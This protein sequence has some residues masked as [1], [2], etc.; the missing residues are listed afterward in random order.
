MARL[1]PRWHRPNR[2]GDSARSHAALRHACRPPPPAASSS[3][4]SGSR[5]GDDNASAAVAAVVAAT[6]R[7]TYLTKVRARDGLTLDVIRS[8][9]AGVIQRIKDVFLRCD[10]ESLNMAQFVEL[11]SSGIADRL[12]GATTRRDLVASLVDLF[13][14]M[15][16]DSNMDLEFEEFLATV[17]QLGMASAAAGPGLE[18]VPTYAAGRR[19]SLG[20]H[21]RDPDRVVKFSPV[22]D[23]LVVYEPAQGA[24]SLYHPAD[25]TKRRVLGLNRRDLLCVEFMERGPAG[26]PLNL[27]AAANADAVMIWD[28]SWATGAPTPVAHRYPTR[29]PQTSL[30]WSP[31]HDRLFTGSNSGAVHVVHHRRTA[32]ACLA[33]R[34]HSHGHDEMVACMDVLDSIDTLATGSLDATVRLW[35]IHTGHSTR[36][37]KAHRKGVA[38]LAYSAEYKFLISAGLDRDACVWSPFASH[39]MCKLTGHVAPLVDVQFVSGTPQIV[40]AD[41]DGVVK[42]WDA[43]NFQCCQTLTALPSASSFACCTGPHRRLVF[44]SDDDA[45]A[46]VDVENGPYWSS[47]SGTAGATRTVSCVLY[48]PYALSFAVAVGNRLQIWDGLKGHLVSVAELACPEI[49]AMCLGY[50]GKKIIVG[51]GNGAIG[52]YNYRNGTFLKSLTPHVGG[53][54]A[55]LLFI[56][57]MKAVVSVGAADQAIVVHDEQP[58]ETPHVFYRMRLPDRVAITSVHLSVRPAFLIAAGDSAGRVHL[59]DMKMGRLQAVLRCPAPIT[60]VR[61]LGDLPLLAAADVN[62]DVCIW[63]TRPSKLPGLIACRLANSQTSVSCI[64]FDATT[65]TLFAGDDDGVVRGWRLRALIDSLGDGTRPSA[66]VHVQAE[67]RLEVR[68]GAQAVQS[69]LCEPG[70]RAVL[71]TATIDSGEHRPVPRIWSV[72]DDGDDG[73]LLGALDDAIEIE[74]PWRLV[75]DIDRVE[76]DR[77]AYV[78]RFMECL[79]HRQR[80]EHRDDFLVFYPEAQVARIRNGA[81]AQPDTT[82]LTLPGAADAPA[83]DAARSHQ[84]GP[85]RATQRGP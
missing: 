79:E 81:A 56:D 1:W 66:G 48:N 82:P 36:Q 38:G 12:G 37:F 47:S 4:S 30:R 31:T 17:I 76:S 44:C 58:I 34:S 3:S 65:R 52:V 15:D 83:P 43:R 72:A 77:D 40:T 59:W 78:S 32:M 61:F 27:L 46:P 2:A 53:E 41:A 71:A 24:F 9:D 64:D 5:A 25:L 60:S 49:T 20:D 23:R 63:T 69:V 13:K 35:D 8:L 6:P 39:L 10:G 57:D 11:L 26:D 70:G 16:L 75:L 29:H 14:S 85:A 84:V 73:A 54:V 68:V 74:R 21:S 42:V 62:G 33:R 19:V 22:N 67:K 55:H 80:R 18:P 51:D 45:W 28:A 50:A 7:S